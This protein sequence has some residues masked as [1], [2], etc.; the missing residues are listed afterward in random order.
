MVRRCS[1][2]LILVGVAFAQTP[3]RDDLA[4]EKAVA[5]F[6]SICEA[7]GKALWGR[8]LC[9]P[10]VIVNPKSH[11]TVASEQDPDKKFEKRGGVF[12]GV[13]PSTIDVANTAV[14]WGGRKWTMVMA[15]LPV[16]PYAQ[17]ALVAHEAF[18]RIQESMDLAGSD[19]PNA[20]LDTENGRLWFRLE[21]RALARALRA[22]NDQD[23]RKSVAYF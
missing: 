14:D 18:H 5:R 1:S 2:T 12:V 10:I 6:Q 13:L 7:Q 16:D 11:W 4:S 3:S 21:L 19:Q 22:E 23:L 17:V 15:P 8:S 20:H 9:G